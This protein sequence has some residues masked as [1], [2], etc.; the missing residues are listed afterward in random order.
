MAYSVLR[1]GDQVRP[2]IRATDCKYTEEK[3]LQYTK[4]A[5]IY[6]TLNGDTPEM[7]INQ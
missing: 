7:S 1:I 3:E 4:S 2:V 5:T 6:L